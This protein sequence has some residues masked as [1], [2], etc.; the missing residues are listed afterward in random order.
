VGRQP[1]HAHLVELCLWPLQIILER[2]DQPCV[3]R[4]GPWTGALTFLSKLTSDGDLYCS[5]RRIVDKSIAV[6]PWDFSNSASLSGGAHSVLIVVDE[7]ALGDHARNVFGVDIV[8]AMPRRGLSITDANTVEA[9]QHCTL[10]LLDELSKRPELLDSESYRNTTRTHLLNMLVSLLDSGT[11]A[12]PLSPPSTRSY[13]LEKADEYMYKKIADPLDISD[14]CESIRVSPRT[15]RYS[16]EELVGVSP[17]HYL[18]ALRL[19]RVRR[20]LVQLRG[21]TQIRCIAER[22]GFAHMGRF[23][24]AYADA[25]GELPSDTCRRARSRSSA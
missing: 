24:Q 5:G 10:T 2:M 21:C 17:T 18:Q 22:H 1:F 8:P 14:L 6:F 7:D 9:F 23:A 25:F 19:G 11:A 12:K 16:F 20:E 13:V 3:Y 4:G 15:L